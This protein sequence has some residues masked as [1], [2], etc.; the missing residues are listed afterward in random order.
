MSSKSSSRRSTEGSSLY[1]STEP[2]TPASQPT[3]SPSSSTLKVDPGI[4]RGCGAQIGWILMSSGKR[5]PVEANARQL[6]VVDAK[7][8]RGRVSEGFEP[9]W[10]NCPARERFKHGPMD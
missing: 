6:V 4:C 3:P 7:T 10:A 8:G 5:M 2:P 9:H 1:G